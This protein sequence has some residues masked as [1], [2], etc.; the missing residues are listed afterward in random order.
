MTVYRTSNLDEKCEWLKKDNTGVAALN[1][2]NSIQC[3]LNPRTVSNTTKEV[4]SQVTG[5]ARTN[6]WTPEEEKG[7]YL[8]S[9]VRPVVFPPCIESRMTVL[10]VFS[11]GRGQFSSRDCTFMNPPINMFLIAELLL[12]S[13]FSLVYCMRS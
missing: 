1:S 7:K 4:R 9:S 12:T 11:L 3:Q 6:N 8:S 5:R 13:K 2:L 10:N